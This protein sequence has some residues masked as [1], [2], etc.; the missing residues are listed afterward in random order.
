MDDAAKPLGYTLK[1]QQ[2]KVLNG[3]ED[4]FAVLATGYSK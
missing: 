4:I 2:R 3:S 1:E